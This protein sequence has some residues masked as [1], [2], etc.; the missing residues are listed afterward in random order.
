[1]ILDPQHIVRVY[2]YETLKVLETEG[3]EDHDS[4]D[5]LQIEANYATATF[6]IELKALNDAEDDVNLR[7]TPKG[8]GTIILNGTVSGATTFSGAITLES[9]LT[10]GG[11]I[12]QT[13]TG[14]GWSLNLLNITSTATVGEGTRGLRVN[15]TTSPAI[16]SGDMQC[17]HGYMTLGAGASLAAGAAIGPLSG[18][19]EIPDTTTVGAGAVLCGVR[20]IFD[21]NN[22]DLGHAGAGYQAA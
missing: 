17:L 18:W 19:L 7:L 3:R 4:H 21:A 1:M 5:Y 11:A 10:L 12:Q 13:L 8:S 9:T 6:M 20:S 15:M 14:E 16:V 2:D 22:N